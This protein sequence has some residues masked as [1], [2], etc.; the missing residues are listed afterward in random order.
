MYKSDVATELGYNFLAY[1]AACNSD[2]AIPSASDG[3]KPVA[4]RILFIMDD[5]GTRSNKP[6]KKC[7]KTVGSVMGRVHPHGDT[8]IYEAMVRLSQPWAMRYPLL[9][10]HGNQGTQAGDGA[11]A[12][13]YTESRLSKIAEAGL[14]AGLK[15]R[16]VDFVPTFDDTEEEPVALPS[17]FPNLLCNP[18][19]GIGVA[20]ACS[21]LPH[22]LTEVGNAICAYLEDSSVNLLDYVS[23]PD[24]PTGGKIVNGNEVKEAYKTG[25]GRAIVRARYNI[26]A[27]GRKE[28]L[29]FYEVPFGV[30]TESLLNQ[31]NVACEKEDIVG[32][33]EVRDESNKKSLRIVIE[34]SKGASP[35]RVASQLYKTT[36]LQ[37]SCNFNQVAL[38]DKT[39]TL[40]NLEDC[41]KIYIKTNLDIICREA[42]FDLDR[43]ESR[44][45]IVNGLLKALEDIDNIIAL[46]KKS[47]SSA[48][49]KEALIEK[50]DF[51]EVQAK[52]I[53]DMKLGKLAGLEKIELQNEKA[54]LDSKKS[55]LILLLSSEANQKKELEKRLSEF[56][57][58]FGDARRTEVTNLDLTNKKT[59]E[60]KAEEVIPEDVVVIMTQ[61]GYIKRVPKKSFRTQRRNG[62]GVKNKD[63][64][65]LGTIKTNTQDSLMLFA[66]NG[67]MFKVLVDNIPESTMGAKGT[68]ISD[69]IALEPEEEISAMTALQYKNNPKYVLFFTKQ[70]MVKKTKLE[71][72]SKVKKGKKG[73][74]AVKIKDG[75]AIAN[76]CF[77]DEEDALIV[78][79]KGMSIRFSTSVIAPIG[80][81]AIGV[82]SIK[83]DEDDEVIGGLIIK[84]E[85]EK[86]A[87][88]S[89]KGMSKKCDLSEFP[90]QNRGGKGVLIYKPTGA[91][92]ELV[93]ATLLS[94]VD[95]VLL[96]GRPNCICIAS[97]EIPMTTRVSMGNI[98]TKSNIESVVK[99]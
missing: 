67:K 89:K 26:E 65:L 33:D 47:E 96:I 14:L 2:R 21:W 6:H 61:S 27:R 31:I 92:G 76:V 10:W 94:D 32:I 51:L 13:R 63:D 73:I 11:A 28:M 55:E 25:K 34:L 84:D 70:G 8:A 60:Q 56:V 87:V 72:Y 35:D 52:A 97:T 88:F 53:I 49:A 9:D 48:K 85:S 44:L 18:N 39:P 41:V 46:I 59:D 98:M 37:K 99:I 79:K 17:L 86:V 75:D 74:V 71:E 50:Y 57:K 78:T 7:A 23:A 12:M 42:K 22:N 62:K 83:L 19:S 36:D 69:I 1:A 91:T 82:K 64:I 3:L 45:I 24:F 66:T 90:V 30:N 16:N 43:T 20:L 4:K 68:R 77:A 15:K 93:G 58:A 40:L 54:E 81:I 38:V 80:K 5:E 95:N 29:V